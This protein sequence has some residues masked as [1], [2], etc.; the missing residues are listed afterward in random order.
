MSK[1]NE[2]LRN[3]GEFMVETLPYPRQVLGSNLATQARQQPYLSSSVAFS[4]D[5]DLFSPV[6]SFRR[7]ESNKSLHKEG[8][9]ITG[10]ALVSIS[11]G[12]N[13]K[14]FPAESKSSSLNFVEKHSSSRNPVT[15]KSADF[16]GNAFLSSNGKSLPT[17]SRQP[18]ITNASASESTISYPSSSSLVSSMTTSSIADLS[19]STCNLETSGKFTST[20]STN[21]ISSSLLP[22]SSSKTLG[23][24][25]FSSS[26][27]HLS[28][29][30]VEHI[31]PSGRPST[32]AKS[33]S[34]NGIRA[35]S[36]C[37]PIQITGSSRGGFDETSNTYSNLVKDGSS[38]SLKKPIATRM[39]SVTSSSA[40]VMSTL[41]ST[42]SDTMENS[43]VCAKESPEYELLLNA[44]ADSLLTIRMS[45][46][47][48]I[49]NLHLE[50][51]RQF[52]MQ[53]NELYAWMENQSRGQQKLFEEI[54]TLREENRRLRRLL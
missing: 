42:P 41:S 32:F 49:Q 19:F 17:S 9:T 3:G 26:P 22:L 39:A 35:E 38:D 54:A 31:D 27:F 10:R 1:R 30:L 44:L 4:G 16:T 46:R 34:S 29:H 2:D 21:T 52:H 11:N 53:Q 14:D 43:S 12:R 5:A 25:A 13:V 40:H 28:S 7:H 6:K 18:N 47:E 23:A 33:S 20:N 48:D 45:L 36:T 50:I 8:P 51:L 37:L 15:L 24:T